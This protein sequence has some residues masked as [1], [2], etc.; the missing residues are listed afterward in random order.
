M[1]FKCIY[2]SDFAQTHGSV[3]LEICNENQ[4]FSFCL[5]FFEWLRRTSI[6]SY[7]VLCFEMKL[8]VLYY[9]RRASNELGF[10]YF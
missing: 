4:L 8:H 10:K 9:L 2:K 5:Q 7:E 1:Q 6:F 3:H